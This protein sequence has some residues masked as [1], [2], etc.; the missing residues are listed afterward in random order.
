MINKKY[1][2]TTKQKSAKL[3][4]LPLS[5]VFA[6]TVINLR[7]PN[8]VHATHVALDLFLVYYRKIGKFFDNK[9]K[10]LKCFSN[11]NLIPPS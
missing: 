6:V 1:S 11:K 7:N 3:N 2:S 5:M 10:S 8:Q 4:C 9:N